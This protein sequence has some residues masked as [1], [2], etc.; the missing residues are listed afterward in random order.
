MYIK[1]HSLLPKD[2][3]KI[4]ETDQYSPPLHI[5]REFGKL[6]SQV[7]LGRELKTYSILEIRVLMSLKR[8]K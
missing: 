5:H 1:Y 2:C 7:I 6:K 8:S 3:K 4:G